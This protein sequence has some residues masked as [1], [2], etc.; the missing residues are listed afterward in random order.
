[1]LHWTKDLLNGYRHVVLDVREERWLDKKA[2][3]TDS[4]STDLQPR[5]FTPALVD[6][7]QDLVQLLLI[8]LRSLCCCWIKWITDNSCSRQFAASLQ[9]GIVN[10]LLDKGP[11]SRAAALALKSEGKKL[12]N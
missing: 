3:L 4:L 1:M 12:I 5:S 2:T 10:R 8:N 7:R 11:G 6:Q 9:E